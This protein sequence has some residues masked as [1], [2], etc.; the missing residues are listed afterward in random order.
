MNRHASYP[1]T[2]PTKTPVSRRVM[3]WL[4]WLVLFI[5][6]AAV[7]IGAVLVIARL[8]VTEA[9]LDSVFLQGMTAGHQIC[10]GGV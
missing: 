10:R 5:A 1:Y 3:R 4:R 7:A 8:H 6:L 9:Q 2:Y